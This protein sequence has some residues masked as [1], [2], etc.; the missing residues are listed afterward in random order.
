MER[1]LE[2]L[3][4]Q[5]KVT[6]DR[7]EMELDVLN[8]KLQATVTKMNIE[9]NDHQRRIG[10]LN[11]RQNDSELKEQELERKLSDEID[12]VRQ[13]D[14]RIDSLMSELTDSR[15]HNEDLKLAISDMEKLRG[16]LAQ[17]FD[18]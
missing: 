11:A 17:K 7:K 6:L 14:A 13:R 9:I 5:H 18:D 12:Q 1:D 2:R 8:D 3:T 10:E 15:K 4:D 16:E